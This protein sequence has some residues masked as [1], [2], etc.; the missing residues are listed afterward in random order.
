MDPYI[1]NRYRG[2]R[3]DQDSGGRIPNTAVSP[4][5]GWQG[6]LDDARGLASAARRNTGGKEKI[7]LA[8]M[9][10]GC[11]NSAI[12]RMGAYNASQTKPDSTV[13]REINLAE[14]E[15]ASL[16]EQMGI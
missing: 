3:P 15:M 9:A 6:D 8:Q 13:M 1:I 16:K 5:R 4:N 10:I 14:T 7:A 11:Y 2:P 12:E